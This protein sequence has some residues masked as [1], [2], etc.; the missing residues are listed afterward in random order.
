MD[1]EKILLKRNLPH[2]VVAYGN[3]T[4]EELYEQGPV[5]PK[6]VI[7]GMAE[8]NQNGISLLNISVGN[9]KEGVTKI[10][11]SVIENGGV[12]DK[13]TEQWVSGKIPTL[14][15]CLPEG[16]NII[17]FKSDTWALGEFLVRTVYHPE[18]KSIPK[19]FMKS[20]ILLD[21]F[22]DS[23]GSEAE[24]LKKVLILD[25]YSREFTWN[26]LKEESGG[27]NIQ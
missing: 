3:G 27:C 11:K 6:H 21:K 1:I 16:E 19:R 26:I 10:D 22:I 13:K 8:L 5:Y 4:F 17:P 15:E 20:Q 12:Y 9:S 25:P 14:N 18:G 24:F 23:L 7:R 2:V